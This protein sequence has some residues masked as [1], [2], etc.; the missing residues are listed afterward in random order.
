MHF[1]FNCKIDRNFRW[2][3]S[4]FTVY[5][6][7]YQLYFFFLHWKSL[8]SSLQFHIVV[9]TAVTIWDI[10]SIWWNNLCD[11]IMHRKD[12]WLRI[13][14]VRFQHSVLFSQDG[15]FSFDTLLHSWY[16]IL[17]AFNKKLQLFWRSN[18]WLSRSLFCV[19]LE[20]W[21][22]RAKIKGKEVTILCLSARAR[23]HT[24]THTRTNAEKRERGGSEQQQQQKAIKT[25][26]SSVVHDIGG[27]GLLQY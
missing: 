1:F 2:V 9:F 3:K 12:D 13:L 22:N 23:T 8:T 21:L 18:G 4:K 26:K 16:I 17:S 27:K 19:I 14:T 20:V 15:L 6:Q 11:C 24:Q 7:H 10:S 5:L 25:I